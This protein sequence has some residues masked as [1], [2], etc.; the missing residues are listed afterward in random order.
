MILN[1]SAAFKILHLSGEKTAEFLQSQLT[2]DV[3]QCQPGMLQWQ[4]YCNRQGLVQSIFGLW[5]VGQDYYILI[6]AEVLENTLSLLQK[7]AVFSRVKIFVLEGTEIV[8]TLLH[9]TEKNLNLAI[10]N[11]SEK[12]L[13]LIWRSCFDSLFHASVMPQEDMLFLRRL[14][15]HHHFPWLSQ[16]TIN[17]FRPHDINLPELHIINFKKGCFP[18]QEIIARMHYR[19]TPKQG[20]YIFQLP[21]LPAYSPG[22]IL[23]KDDKHIGQIV[24]VVCLNNRT[25]LSA[26]LS[27]VE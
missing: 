5:G 26:V 7:Y 16:T 24:D 2:N 8:L 15:I 19:G 12:K 22:Q 1:V 14:L 25:Y 17:V 18:G 23:M 21:H 9:Q 10:E 13:Q 11:F 27:H 3:K 20:L 6:A 4:A